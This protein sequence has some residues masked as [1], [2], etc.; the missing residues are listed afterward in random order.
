MGL[1]FGEPSKATREFRI[2]VRGN[3]ESWNVLEQ[4]RIVMKLVF[5]EDRLSSVV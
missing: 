1:D 4:R 3:R 5:K 2:Y